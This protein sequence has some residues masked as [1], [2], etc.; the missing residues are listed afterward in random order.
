MMLSREFSW[1]LRHAPKGPLVAYIDAFT[2]LLRTQG[3]VETSV[4][5]HTRLVADFS[6]W[7]KK[8]NVTKEE[9]TLEH[10][11]RYL[12][13]RARH[14]RPRTGDFAVLKQLLRLLHEQGVITLA[15]APVAPAQRLLDEYALY[16]R[17]ERGLAP[18]T[19]VNYL[20]VIRSFLTERFGKG[21]LQLSLLCAADVVLFVRRQ[22]GRVPPKVAKL[23]TTALRS[24]LR[25]ARYR[26]YVTIDLAAGVP[27]VANWS[28]ASIPRSI[29]PDHVRRV[30]G[31]CNRQSAVGCRDYAILLL[32]ARLGLRAGEVAFLKLEDIDWKGS[33]LYV[34]NKGSYRTALPLPAEVGESDR[35]VPAKG[36][37]Y[38]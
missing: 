15:S 2:E 1:S 32:L 16:L 19:L 12:R 6:G 11:K 30:L 22:A 4:Q 18:S 17:Q 13:Y 5:L 9:I 3:Y 26:D 21:P 33:C 23:P 34:G 8:K 37:S 38:E 14:Q 28:M 7:L 36:A 10:T 29:E 35:H 24:F 31:E 20:R 27:T 25:Y